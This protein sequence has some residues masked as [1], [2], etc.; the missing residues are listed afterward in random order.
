MGAG[1]VSRVGYYSLTETLGKGKFG[2]VR[3]GRHDFTGEKVAVKVLDKAALGEEDVALLFRELRIHG[4]IHHP[5]VMRLY[6]VVDAGKEL[7]LVLEYCPGGS[8]Q[9]RLAKTGPMG[10]DEARAVFGQ[11]VAAMR[12]VHALGIVHRDLKPGNILL[13]GRGRVKIGDFGFA[14]FYTPGTELFR[15]CGTPRFMAPELLRASPYIGP[16]VDVYALGVTLYGLLTASDPFGSIPK[17]GRKSRE[18]TAERAKRASVGRLDPHPAIEAE[19]DVGRL[20]A[21]MIVRPAHRATLGDVAASPWLAGTPAASW[22]EPP[23][24]QLELP[25]RG[26]GLD[27]GIIDAL[28]QMGWERE[29]LEE[30]LTADA[31]DKWRPVPA[32]PATALEFD[33]LHPSDEDS[34]TSASANLIDQARAKRIAAVYGFPSIAVPMLRVYAMLVRKKVLSLAYRDAGAPLLLVEHSMSPNRDVTDH[35]DALGSFSNDYFSIYEEV[36]V[37]AARPHSPT[38]AR[39]PLRRSASTTLAAA[40]GRPPRGPRRDSRSRSRSASASREPRSARTRSAS[41]QRREASAASARSRPPSLPR[42]GPEPVRTRS[43]ATSASASRPP[44]AVR[45]AVAAEPARLPFRRAGKAGDAGTAMP[46]RRNR[47]RTTSA[48]RRRVGA[49]SS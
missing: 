22:V 11:I 30:A 1:T 44:L 24:P 26:G 29:A 40:S 47:N 7:C 18:V 3:L 46:A 17:A 9:A 38:A 28:V 49:P 10:E 34:P 23:F 5:N 42:S 2:H 31:L 16:Q 25:Q 8:L 35:G 36:G 15:C 41:A 43:R 48:S 13:D 20:L 19:T 12:Y 45:N 21:A 37:E 4:L 6:D 39:P 33:E 27:N 32:S 14:R